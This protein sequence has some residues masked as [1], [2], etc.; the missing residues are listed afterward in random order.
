MLMPT[1][2]WRQLGLAALKGNIAIHNR[3]SDA[4]IYCALASLFRSVPERG[5]WTTKP[6][7][8][9]CGSRRCRGADE[10]QQRCDQLAPHRSHGL[11]GRP[12]RSQDRLGRRRLRWRDRV[13]G[14]R[15]RYVGLDWSEAMVARARA[16]YRDVAGDGRIALLSGSCAALPFANARFDRVLA[17]H[18]LYFW[19]PPERHLQEIRRELRPC[20]QLCLAFGGKAFNGWAALHRA[21]LSALWPGR[22]GSL[23]S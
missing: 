12:L 9:S 5:P 13:G 6:F 15:V 19:Q 4:N 21:R 3:E 22:C 7:P 18:A 2:Y 14:S 16:R 20:G 17:V 11:G 1:A 10:P 23:A 8:V